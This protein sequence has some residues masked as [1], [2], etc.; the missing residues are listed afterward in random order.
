MYGRVGNSIYVDMC[1]G[2]YHCHCHS[3]SHSHCQSISISIPI[4]IP[5]DLSLSLSI[6][7]KTIYTYIY[8]ILYIY[9]SLYRHPEGQTEGE[10]WGIPNTMA[11]NTQMVSVMIWEYPNFRKPVKN[12]VHPMQVF[13]LNILECNKHGSPDGVV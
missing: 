8:I 9:L 2:H 6:Y 4:S 13:A 10:H 11:F 5:L 3:H 7:I 12:D 1:H